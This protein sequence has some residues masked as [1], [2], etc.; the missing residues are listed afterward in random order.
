MLFFPGFLIL[1]G[2][3]VILALASRG[4]SSLAAR[5]TGSRPFEL[6]DVERPSSEMWK[7]L[8]IRGAGVLSPLFLIMALFVLANLIG[9]EI[10]ATTTVRVRPGPASEAGMQDGDRVVEIDHRPIAE[11]DELLGAIRGTH[12]A[13]EIVV[14]RSGTRST[15]SVTPNAEGRIGIE[16]VYEGHPIGFAKALQMGVERPFEIMAASVRSLLE[17]PRQKPD[18]VGPMGIVRE[19]SIAASAG[20]ARW[21]ALLGMIASCFW[22]G[23]PA[24]HLIDAT[25]LSAFRRPYPVEVSAA[26]LRIARLRQLLGLL[27]VVWIALAA[28][29]PFADAWPEAR[30]LKLM[31]LPIVWLFPPVIA[32]TWHLSRSL[33]GSTAAVLSALTQLLPPVNLILLFVLW[34]HAG[35]HLNERGLPKVEVLPSPPAG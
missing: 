23:F 21:L 31:V 13:H 35:R 29:L 16:S 8:V 20:A 27:V 32:V 12:T 11:W 3:V 34:R 9:G 7:E 33:W 5:V 26:T 6:F 24:V 2:A 30:P 4:A 28:L 15:L 1:V 17:P 25:G 22:P 14:E 10:G 19:T 18:L